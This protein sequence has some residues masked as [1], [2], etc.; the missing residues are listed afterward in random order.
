MPQLL[1]RS[2][3]LELSNTFGA[4]SR[5]GPS[6]LFFVTR[7]L[8]LLSRSFSS[9]LCHPEH[10]TNYFI[11]LM[12]DRTGFPSHNSGNATGSK[13]Q[14]ANGNWPSQKRKTFTTEDAEEHRGKRRKTFCHSVAL[15][16][17]DFEIKAENNGALNIQPARRFG[18]VLNGILPSKVA[19]S[20]WQMAKS[21][22]KDLHH[23][24]R[25]GAQ[26]KT[27]ENLFAAD[28][29]G[30]AQILRAKTRNAE[31]PLRG[32]HFIS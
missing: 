11:P 24:G 25:R 5:D 20:K 17:T 18:V 19:K 12:F 23:R 4:P 28:L 7:Q 30:S 13:W 26:R 8:H 10:E 21:K 16:S 32:S 6:T 22:A 1:P 14:M 2:V 29:R 31:E 3:T 27:E 9:T 15:I